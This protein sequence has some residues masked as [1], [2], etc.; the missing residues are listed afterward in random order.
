[1]SDAFTLQISM[2]DRQL[3]FGISVIISETIVKKLLFE[4]CFL[5]FFAVFSYVCILCFCNIATGKM[6]SIFRK[7]D[8]IFFESVRGEFKKFHKLSFNVLI[9]FSLEIVVCK[10]NK[11][12]PKLLKTS[13]SME[14]L[15]R[16]FFWK[17]CVFTWKILDRRLLKVNNRNNRKRCEICSKLT[18]KTAERQHSRRSGVFIV[19][20]EHISHNI[21]VFL[22][23][24]LNM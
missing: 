16:K 10:F 17:S 18:I 14:N 13:R 6:K 22:L 15:F 7:S 23:L 3:Q 11:V 21:L 4:I 19:N 9:P 5:F 1:M 12:L 24:T 20:F 8:K 2:V